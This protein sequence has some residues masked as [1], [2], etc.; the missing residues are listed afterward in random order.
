LHAESGADALS[1]KAFDAFLDLWI[2]ADRAYR[3][4]NFPRAYRLYLQA[5]EGIPEPLD[6][7]NEAELVEKCIELKAWLENVNRELPAL[8]AE[9]ERRPRDKDAHLGLARAIEKVGRYE[10]ALTEF[11]TAFDLLETE[12][13]GE[14]DF[15]LATEADCLYGLGLCH[16]RLGHL[17][18]ALN[19][20]KQ[21]D[22]VTVNRAA[23]ASSYQKAR[24]HRIVI[25]CRLRQRQEAERESR[26]YIRLFG[27]LGQR[28]REG[29]DTL[30]LDGDAFYIEC[31][32]GLVESSR[33]SGPA[34]I[35]AS[36][37]DGVPGVAGRL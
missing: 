8:K 12:E 2:A 23:E 33:V 21:V 9:A 15:L 29:L 30:E 28:P 4:E 14:L 37:F 22:A 11:Q 31:H 19:F 25:H 13:P 18:T 35:D 1:R 5:W 26:E 16:Y 10:E 27:R 20:F 17:E 34:L 24:E 32:R 6:S 36:V 3:A 7:V